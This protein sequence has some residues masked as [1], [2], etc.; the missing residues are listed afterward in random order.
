MAASKDGYLTLRTV[1]TSATQHQ[2]S[3]RCQDNH[4]VDGFYVTLELAGLPYPLLK[5]Q[6]EKHYN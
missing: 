6:V 3:E 5:C 4:L 1:A 2:T